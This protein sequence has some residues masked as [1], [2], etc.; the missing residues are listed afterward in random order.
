MDKVAANHRNWY[1]N[2]ASMQGCDVF[3]DNNLHVTV[4]TGVKCP[5][6]GEMCA[7][8]QYSAIK[9]DT[10]R[11]DSKIIGVNSLDRPT[12]Q[13]T[14][15]CAPLVTDPYC[16]AGFDPTTSEWTI[17]CYYGSRTDTGSNVTHVQVQSHRYEQ[18]F[19]PSG[20]LIMAISTS[21]GY[22]HFESNRSKSPAFCLT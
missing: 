21:L 11:L 3:V 7:C 20:Y 14:A 5:F 8:G 19:S 6:K 13:R 15:I 1:E 17:S 12:F 16:D 2:D 9:L 22:G 18:L 4:S 10:G